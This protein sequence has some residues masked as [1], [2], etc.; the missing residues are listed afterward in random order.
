[1]PRCMSFQPATG[2]WRRC[3]VTDLSATSSSRRLARV[4][5]ARFVQIPTPHLYHYRLYPTSPV[6]AAIS[7][8]EAIFPSRFLDDSEVRS[9][10]LPSSYRMF[11]FSLNSF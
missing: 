8:N 4:S 1:M 6:A 11:S 2:H 3:R 5:H 10:P 7:I 9:M